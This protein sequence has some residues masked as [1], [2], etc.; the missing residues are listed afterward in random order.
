M[1]HPDYCTD[2]REYYHTLK[3]DYS[4]L[5]E[6]TTEQYYGLLSRV[7]QLTLSVQELRGA[8]ELS[9]LLAEEKVA[10]DL[11]KINLRIFNIEKQTEKLSHDFSLLKI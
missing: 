11:L 7:Q 5:D 4:N 2:A 3:T 9:L 6:V 8:F 10:S 1:E